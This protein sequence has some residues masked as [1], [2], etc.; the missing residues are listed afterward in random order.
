MCYEKI[1]CISLYGLERTRPRVQI[2]RLDLVDL[3]SKTLQPLFFPSLQVYN[4]FLDINFN[5]FILKF[6]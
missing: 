5:P 2:T 4:N 1:L 6:V 3:Q